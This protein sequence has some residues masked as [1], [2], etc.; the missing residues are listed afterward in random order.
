MNLSA[1]M[2]RTVSPISGVLIAVSELA[3]VSPIDLVKRNAIPFGINIF[4]LL[5]LHFVL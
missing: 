2:G 4:M 5:I 3:G 1:S